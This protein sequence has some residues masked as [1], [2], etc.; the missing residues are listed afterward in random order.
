MKSCL[1]YFIRLCLLFEPGL[2]RFGLKQV[3]QFCR[4]RFLVYFSSRP[5]L[6]LFCNFRKKGPRPKWS[7]CK[8]E[9][10]ENKKCLYLSVVSKFCLVSIVVC[11]ASKAYTSL[12]KGL[13]YLLKVGCF[14]L[15]YANAAWF[16]I[17]ETLYLGRL[18]TL[19]Y[20]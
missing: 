13:K 20:V 15:G 6:P 9:S 17:F 1:L 19:S 18:K 2:E 14:I 11:S 3:W 7:I 10:D 8:H 16:L 4:I 12:F 5:M